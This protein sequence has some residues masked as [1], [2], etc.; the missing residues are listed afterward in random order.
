MNPHQPNYYYPT[1]S[2][3]ANYELSILNYPLFCSPSGQLPRAAPFVM[4]TGHAQSLPQGK[5]PLLNRVG[6]A[7]AA[8]A[9]FNLQ[10]SNFQLFRTSVPATTKAA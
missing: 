5:P 1:T 6:K 2:P 7:L 10:L 9:T 4:E 3:Q 8:R